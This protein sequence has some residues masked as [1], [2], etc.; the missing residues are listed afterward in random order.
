MPQ[1]FETAARVLDIDQKRQKSLAY[2]SG[3]SPTERKNAELR[4]RE[5][6]A[7][8]A[9]VREKLPQRVSSYRFALERLVITTPSAQAADVER[10]SI[11]CKLRSRA[12]ARPA[13]T[14]VREQNLA[15]AR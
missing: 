3:L 7:I 1:F 14:W 11:N 10:A 8:V 12:T 15:A 9:L 2:V 4:M 13:P 5:N 6:A